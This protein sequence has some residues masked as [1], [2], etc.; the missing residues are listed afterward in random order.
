M[1]QGEHAKFAVMIEP[2]M[3]KDTRGPRL[4]HPRR[5]PRQRGHH[6]QPAG[7]FWP[8]SPASPGPVRP[9]LRAGR[10][11]HGPRGRPPAAGGTEHHLRGTRTERRTRGLPALGCLHEQ[12]HRVQFA[13]APWL[14]HHMLDEIENL[15]GQLLGNVDSLMERASAAAKS[16]KDRTAPGRPRAGAPPGPAPEPGGKGGTVPPDCPHE[17]A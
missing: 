7:A 10:E 11:L 5:R 1:G 9:L 6:R 2:A 8:S 3:R 13:A 16:L 12:T 15:S 17:P 14:R 4:C